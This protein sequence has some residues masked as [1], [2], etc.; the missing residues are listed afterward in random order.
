MLPQLENG[1][2]LLVAL[3]RVQILLDLE[4]RVDQVALR[5]ANL[6]TRMYRYIYCQVFISHY[7]AQFVFGQSEDLG[8]GQFAKRFDSQ[9]GKIQRL[10]KA[11]FKSRHFY[12]NFTLE[13]SSQNA[14]DLSLQI[15][16]QI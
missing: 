11:Q 5:I 15:F 8:A 3:A 13:N 12:Q 10:E 6:N 16:V 14:E 9:V 4:F 1:F 2:E 7:L